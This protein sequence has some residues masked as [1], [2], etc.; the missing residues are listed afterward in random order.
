MDKKTFIELCRW[1]TK[2][3]TKNY[4]RNSDSY[5]KAITRAALVSKDEKTRIETLMKLRGVSWT[6]ASVIL[7][8][9]FPGKYPILDFRAI[10]SLGFKQPST[11]NFEFWEKYIGEFRKLLIKTRL[12]ERKIDRGLWMYSKVNQRY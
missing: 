3:Q 7:H 5:I 12:S 2:R 4:L 8:F 9:S 10:W 6:V 11:Y 1:K